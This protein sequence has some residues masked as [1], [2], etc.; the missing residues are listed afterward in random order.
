MHILLSRGL[1]LISFHAVLHDEGVAPR[2][3]AD[4]VSDRLVRFRKNLPTTAPCAVAQANWERLIKPLFPEHQLVDQTLVELKPGKIIA[5]LNEELRG[6][7]LYDYP[8]KGSLWPADPRPT[9]RQG[10]YLADDDHALLITDMT[11]R[12]CISNLTSNLYL[13]VTDGLEEEVI[14]FKPKWL[15]QSPSAPVNSKRCRQCARMAR[16]NAQRA[17]E[18]EGPLPFFC[19]LDLTS[20]NRHEILHVADILM[21]PGASGKKVL[22]FA[23]WLERTPILETIKKWQEAF[24]KVGVMEGDVKD[25]RFLCAMTLRDCTV[26]VRTSPVDVSEWDSRIGDLDLKSKD[27]AEYW[28]SVE[29]PLIEEGW[30]E[31]TEKD[32]DWQP[33]ACQLSPERFSTNADDVEL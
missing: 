21:Q 19:P 11:P 5:K 28:R 17:R 29:R 30:Y 14:E 26:F 6:W 22:R 12:K 24:D 13:I 9:K 10:T 1:S 31:G 20:K 18:G 32:E 16:Y 27:K 3:A 8:T 33:I 4:S 15:L 2:C 23:E 25:E 7:E